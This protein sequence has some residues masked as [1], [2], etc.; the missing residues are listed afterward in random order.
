MSKDNAENMQK[1]FG[2]RI[3]GLIVKWLQGYRGYH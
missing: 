2:N 3:N 1:V